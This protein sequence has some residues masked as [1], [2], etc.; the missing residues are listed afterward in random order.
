[1]ELSARPFRLLSSTTP[2]FSDRLIKFRKSS[3]PRTSSRIQ[4]ASNLQQPQVSKDQEN[5]ATMSSKSQGSE[6]RRHHSVVMNNFGLMGSVALQMA[7]DEKVKQEENANLIER[8]ER[9]RLKIKKFISNSI[10]GHFYQNSLLVLSIFSCLQF[11]YQSYLKT[12]SQSSSLLYIFD[13]IEKILACLFGWDWCL[14]IF[15]ADHKLSH[16]TR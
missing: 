2:Y 1:M 11:I 4:M 9:F 7:E 16:V 3:P 6:K 13:L 8:V 10:W 15:L 14:Q 5:F 12:S